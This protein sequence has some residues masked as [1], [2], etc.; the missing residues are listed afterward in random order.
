M[1]SRIWILAALLV[2]TGSFRGYAEDTANTPKQERKEYFR[3]EKQENKVWRDNFETRKKAAFES[4][5]SQGLSD[6]EI[7]EKMAPFREEAKEH[8]LD[9]R[10]EHKEYMQN[11]K[12]E[13]HDEFVTKAD[14]NKDGKVDKDEWKTFQKD[15]KGEGWGKARRGDRPW[16]N[17][18]HRDA[19]WKKS[20]HRTPAGN[21]SN[22]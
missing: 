20:G 11:F 22:S 17:K 13:R 8:H 12:K 4:Y 9:E 21:S 19:G 2:A 7:G 18:G 16:G 5:K 10:N 1:K 15:H 3:K 6:K 14:A